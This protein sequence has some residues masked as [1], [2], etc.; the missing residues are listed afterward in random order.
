MQGV[1]KLMQTI[2]KG[3]FQQKLRGGFHII[4]CSKPLPLQV[5]PSKVRGVAVGGNNARFGYNLEE[6]GFCTKQKII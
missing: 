5:T 3:D 4:F 2:L 1:S 6:K